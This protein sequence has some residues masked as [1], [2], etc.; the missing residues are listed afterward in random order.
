MQ[1]RLYVLL[2]LLAA[3][4]S[5]GGCSKDASSKPVKAAAAPKA[6]PVT[7]EPVQM[8]AEHRVFEVTGTLQPY[9]SVSVSSEVDGTVAK[10][11]VDLGDRV[12]QGQILAELDRAEF[13]IQL[14]QASASL[15]QVMARLGVKPGEDP[16]AIR[17]EDTTDVMK[18]R[19]ALDEAQLTYRRA[20]NL[21]KLEIGTKQAM[22]TAEAAFK[23]A[24][25]NYRASHDQVR[26]L[27]AQVA[28]YRAAVE[29]ARKKL[30]DTTIR[31]PFS[32]QVQERNVGPGQ[33]LKA[34]APA[35]LIVQSNPLRLRAE[36]AERF[37]RSIRANQQVKVTVDGVAQPFTARISRISPAVTQQS[38]TLLVEALVDNGQQLL[39]PGAFARASIV[40]D[41]T[42][43]VL[44]VPATAVLNYY[45]IN[46]VFTVENDKV[47]ERQVKLGDRFGEKYEVIEGLQAQEVVATSNLEKLTLGT[48]VQVERR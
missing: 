23:T 19:A 45:G 37:A 41:Q 9:E 4:V 26:A 28:Q 40:S 7:A 1:A 30:S 35:F 29:L 3:V 21:F 38:R 25:A 8:Q 17:E 34:Q 24:E 22:D 46:K 32:G 12:Q 14:N 47:R 33:F 42:E 44:L 2:I 36:V 20:Q 13:Q 27:K 43:R 18:A 5:L 10:I 16:Q 15:Q 11:H 39:R 6:L 48:T 31:A